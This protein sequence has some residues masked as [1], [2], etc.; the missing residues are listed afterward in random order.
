MV[1]HI[2]TV[3]D[4]LFDHYLGLVL[5]GLRQSS[6]LTNK[7]LRQSLRLI[8]RERK[9]SFQNL[10]EIRKKCSIYKKY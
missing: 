2:Q 6:N 1:K 9:S 7:I 4:E 5:K 10:L 8:Y 3:A